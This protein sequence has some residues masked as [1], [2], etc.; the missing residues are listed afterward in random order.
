MSQFLSFIL[1][2]SLALTLRPFAWLIA[3]WLVASCPVLSAQTPQGAA[4]NLDQTATERSLEERVAA[5][6]REVRALLA[7]LAATSGQ[8]RVGC[9]DGTSAVPQSTLERLEALDEQIRIL[10]RR[11]ELE[12]GREAE[13]TKQAPVVDAGTR[14]FGL[15]SSDGSFLLSLRG[16]M[17]VDG[18]WFLSD[19]GQA[20]TD[21]LVARRVRPI[22]LATLF[23]QV[24]VRLMPDFGDGRVLV[25]DAQVD[26]RFTSTFRL[27]A[28]K[29]K[30]PFGLERLTSASD[31]LFLERAFPTGVAP[32]RDVGAM[33]YGDLAVGRLS[34][35]FGLFNGLADGASADLDDQDGKDAVG[36][37]FAQPF[38]GSKGHPLGGLGVGAAASYGE[39]TGVA[40]TPSLASY[41]TTGQQVF[42][43]YRLDGTA[44][45]SAV[46]SGTRYRASLQAYYYAGPVGMLF[47]QAYSSQKLRRGATAGEGGVNAW[48]VAGSWVL[49]GERASHRA[50]VPRRNFDPGSGAWG[51]FELASRYHQL[52][53]GGAAFPVF[54]DPSVGAQRARAWTAGLNWYLN[55]AL[56]LVFNYEETRFRGGAPG[57]ADRGTTRDLLTRLQVAF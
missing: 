56:K 19:A 42:F 44:S 31:L 3:L 8:P 20:F 11:R 1:H 28:G 34:Y 12:R 47:E 27:R 53:V 6:E 9:P 45:G 13:A 49:T 25:Q 30:P 2:T 33:V 7:A 40:S 14:G 29:F 55:P 50:I 37:V 46:A 23:K 52:S 38:A 21:T 4:R 10:D 35:A 39:V 54:A 48:Q 26:V 57:G 15:R 32:N 36:R 43:R 5:L 24:D 16:L 17:Q 41:R 51:A 18:R 22:L